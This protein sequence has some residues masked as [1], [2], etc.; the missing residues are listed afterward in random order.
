MRPQITAYLH[1]DTKEWLTEY[2]AKLRLPCS[3]VVR[4]LVERERQVGWLKWARSVPD[5]AMGS[6]TNLPQRKARLPKHRR[7][8]T[9]R[10]VKR[11]R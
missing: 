5:P 2:A 10:E 8:T 7:L 9:Q 6:P 1:L 3:D 11:H 4:L